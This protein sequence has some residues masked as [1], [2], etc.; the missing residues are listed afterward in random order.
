[1][2][3]V[4]KIKDKLRWH[5][6]K[7]SDYIINS[8]VD[9]ARFELGFEDFSYIQIMGSFETIT[10]ISEGNC[11]FGRFGDGEFNLIF[12]KSIEFQK[13]SEVLSAKLLDI[14]KTDDRNFYVG[15]PKFYFHPDNRLRSP[16]RSF[17]RGWVR[18][19]R[20]QILGLLNT[21]LI[22]Y[23]TC[24][25]QQ[26]AMIE[27]KNLGTYFKIM[28]KIW[29]GKKV[30]VVCG[31][32]SFKNVMP[33]LID[34]SLEISY[35]KGP[36]KD[37]FERYDELLYQVLQYSKD[38][39]VLISLGPTATV[40]AYD[41]HKFGYQAIDIGHAF[42]DYHMFKKNVDMNHSSISNY[43]KAD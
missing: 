21:N 36:S 19:N 30:L 32:N 5:L 39:V 20:D 23:D 40:M 24:S 9:A 8:S 7:F 2:Y 18:E 35:I 12:G 43:Y 29:G 11:S 42:K 33:D 27:D 6:K 28:K 38:T 22:Y 3:I 17:V 15:I 14:L 13:Y 31:E 4:D 1:M 16:Q 25:T 10:C 34:N 41:L 37:A 26:Y